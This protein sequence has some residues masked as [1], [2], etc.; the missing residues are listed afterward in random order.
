MGHR[1]RREFRGYVYASTGDGGKSI[2]CVSMRITSMEEVVSRLCLC[3]YQ[4]WRWEYRVCLY[5]RASDGGGS[6][7]VMSMRVPAVAVGVSSLSLCAGQRRRSCEKM[8]YTIS[9]YGNQYVRVVD[10]TV[11][12]LGPPKF[13]ASDA[14]GIW[15]LCY[16]LTTPFTT[17]NNAL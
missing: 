17:Q 8:G 11:A 14:R 5:A 3:V 4:R 7:E 10:N 15:I 16:G 9:L 6:F 12:R 13:P 1:R 2:E